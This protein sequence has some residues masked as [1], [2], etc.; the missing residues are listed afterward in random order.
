MAKYGWLEFPPLTVE[1]PYF[2]SEQDRDSRTRDFSVTYGTDEVVF[3]RP[4]LA[5][6]HG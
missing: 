1:R 6:S 5:S 3:F 2:P 4:S